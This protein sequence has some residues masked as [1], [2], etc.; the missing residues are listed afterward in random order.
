MMKSNILRKI[1]SILLVL[2][3]L[4]SFSTPVF[5]AALNVDNKV[6][7]IDEYVEVTRLMD[8][9]TALVNDEEITIESQYVEITPHNNL[10][11]APPAIIWFLGLATN[12]II[13]YLTPLV[14]SA[15]LTI[16]RNNMSAIIAGVR[17]ANSWS[18]AG[19]R[20]SVFRSLRDAGVSETNARLL[21]QQIAHIIGL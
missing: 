16:A 15:V 11:T 8:E 17:N 2:A 19:V 6:D 10:A 14:S 1:I 7:V 13:A 5:A 12:R 9:Y 18:H 4:F 20:D 3:F 21:G